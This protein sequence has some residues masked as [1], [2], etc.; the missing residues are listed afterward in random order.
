M[1]GVVHQAPEWPPELDN[2]RSYAAQSN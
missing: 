1:A 2:Y